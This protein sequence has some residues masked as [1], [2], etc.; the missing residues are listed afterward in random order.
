MVSPSN[1]AGEQVQGEAMV[2]IAW[3]ALA[4]GYLRSRAARHG[5]AHQSRKNYGYVLTDFTRFAD[6]RRVRTDTPAAE[7]A[8][9]VDTWLES[10]GWA[11]TTCCTNLG[12]VRPFLDWC[13][14][15]GLVTAGVAPLL[16]NP[17]RPRLL[18]RAQS[19]SQVARLL[20]HV[21]DRRGRA[22]VLL[23][24]QGGLRRGE[25]A[26]LMMGDID[27]ADG[28]ALVHGKGGKERIVWLS[29]E[30]LGAVRSWLV[31]RTMVPG[32][33][34]SSYE[35]PGRPVTPTWVGILVARWMEDAGIKT[36]P[37]D[38]MSGHALRHSAATNLLR[39][40]A[41]I[42]VV[43]EALGHESITTTARYLRADND[44]VR[45]AMRALSYGSRRL[46]AAGAP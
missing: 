19:T 8:V 11:A 6:G 25:V 39:A 10:R 43:Q 38:G 28:R 24:A 17:R 36:M 14:T 15:R 46:R 29:D 16:R 1:P 12:V 42:R 32:A 31:E 35:H 37:H 44:E 41:N 4:D 18:P 2:G 27:L 20:A 23:M 30:T 33:L 26:R 21:P 45:Q 34:I 9:L 3:K 7:L 13:G 5:L 22:I 40:G